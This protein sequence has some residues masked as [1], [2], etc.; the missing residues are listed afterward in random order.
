MGLGV[1]GMV[2]GSVGMRVGLTVE[3]IV[4]NGLS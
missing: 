3:G 1:G 4:S 2:G